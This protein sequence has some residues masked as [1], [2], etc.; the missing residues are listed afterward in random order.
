[1]RFLHPARR[2]GYAAARVLVLAVALIALALPASAAS[3]DDALP[4]AT[5]PPARSTEYLSVSTDPVDAFS[6]M[7]PANK[8]LHATMTSYA[9]TSTLSAWMG[10]FDRDHWSESFAATRAAT[11]DG[12]GRGLEVVFNASSL[13]A[14]ASLVLKASSGSGAYDLEWQVLDRPAV[15]QKL[16]ATSVPYAG[17]AYISGVVTNL[18]A[19]QLAPGQ[20]VLLRQY[21]PGKPWV[22]AQRTTTNSGGFYNFR[23]TPK[24]RTWYRV[25]VIGSG[26]LGHVTAT[27][28]VSVFP[29]AYLSTPYAPRTIRRYA[30]FVTYGAFKP[31]HAGGNRLVKLYGYHYERGRWVKRIDAWTTVSNYSTYSRYS[32]RISFRYTGRWKVRAF[33]S[34]E[35]HLPTYSSYRYVTVR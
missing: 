11:S 20:T 6:F 22:I 17:S 13:D 8:Q 3:S 34:S 4:G 31:R 30:R 35:Q 18:R 2:R 28:E 26:G 24:I 7:V 19:N 33:H 5:P 29:K 32:A 10:V 9:S 16:S 23:V 12:P 1:M 27:N 25:S 15:T 14:S 21:E